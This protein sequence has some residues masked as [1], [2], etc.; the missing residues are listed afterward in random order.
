MYKNFKYLTKQF[1]NNKPIPHANKL[2]C[3]GTAAA[4]ETSE[5]YPTSTNAATEWHANA[6]SE[7]EDLSTTKDLTW[8]TEDVN[9]GNVE[10]TEDSCKSFEA[11]AKGT[12]STKCAKM[13]PVVLE[14]M[15]H[16]TQ[17]EL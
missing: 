16:K 9:D 11:L 1:H 13:T 14:G 12:T 15:P 3:A 7:K 2:Q 8:G 6:K 5:N 17:T 10:R 4:A